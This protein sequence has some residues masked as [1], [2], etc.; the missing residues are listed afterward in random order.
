MAVT[1]ATAKVTLRITTEAFDTEIQNLITAAYADLT[2]GGMITSTS[3][4]DPAASALADQAVL[5]YI[6]A[7]FGSPEEYDRLKKS[8]D[9]QKAQLGSLTGA[10]DWLEV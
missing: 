4:T 1:V 5:T 8:Y 9:E 3:I 6:R 7:N 2:T 10:T